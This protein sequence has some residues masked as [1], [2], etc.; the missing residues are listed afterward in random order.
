MLTIGRTFHSV[1]S[2]TGGNLLL[3][4]ALCLAAANATTC[5]RHDMISGD[6]ELFACPSPSDPDGNKSFCCGS[7]TNRYCCDSLDYQMSENK[8]PFVLFFF[9][10]ILML[11]LGLMW[12]FHRLVFYPVIKGMSTTIKEATKPTPPS[13]SFV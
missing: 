9:I 8:A 12:A 1:F 11:L 3:L 7:D 6:L 13:Y 2:V 5:V 10:S 4:F